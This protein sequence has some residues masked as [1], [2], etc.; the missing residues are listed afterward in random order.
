MQKPSLGSLAGLAATGLAAGIIATVLNWLEPPAARAE[1]ARPVIE[2]AV[3]TLRHEDASDALWF[4][5]WRGRTD[6]GT[7]ARYL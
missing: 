3:F 2:N 6:D 4:K 5:D 1:A 7:E